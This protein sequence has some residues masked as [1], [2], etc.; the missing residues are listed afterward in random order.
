MGVLMD[1]STLLCKKVVITQQLLC[2]CY[3]DGAVKLKLNESVT[4]MSNDLKMC[5]MLNG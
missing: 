2:L 1:S 4:H 5:D 3:F